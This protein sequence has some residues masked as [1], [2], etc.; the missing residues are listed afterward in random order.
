MRHFTRL[1][2]LKLLAGM[3]AAAP[4]AASSVAITGAAAA[5]PASTSSGTPLSTAKV[6]IVVGPVQSETAKYIADGESAYATAI[7]YSSNVV[8]IYSPNATWANVKAALTGASVVLY[9]GH[10]NGWPSPYPADPTYSKMDG[11]GLN[12]TANNGDSKTQYYGEPSLA[13]VSMAPNA[14]V[15]LNHLCYASGNSEPQNAAPTLSVAKQRADNFGQGFI[16]AGARAVIAEGH[17]SIDGMIRDLFTTHQSVVDLWRTQYDYHHNEFSFQSMRN[18]AY[19]VFMDPDQPTGGY[20]RSFVGN[21]SVR[22][23]NVTGVPFVPTDTAPAT[24]QSPGA[25]TVPAGGANLYNDSSLTS[26][27]SSLA[28]GTN[29]RVE[30]LSNGGSALIVGATPPPTAYVRAMDGSAEGWTAAPALTPQDSTGPQ[31]WGLDGSLAIS[32][33]GDGV[34]DTMN[35]AVRFSESVTW[36]A[37]IL[38]S[39]GHQAWAATGSGA[40]TA[41]T[42][43]A[44]VSGALV[45]NGTYALT[46]RAQDAWGN[47]PL[48]DSLTLTIDASVLPTRLSGADRY[49]TAAAISKA[50]YA[51]GV[52]VAYVASGLGFADALAGAAAAGKTGG[53]LLT[54]PGTTIPAATAAE[55][56]RLKP[57]RIIV[58]GGTSVVSD[59]VLV[60]MKGSIAS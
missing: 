24:L 44:K 11:L 3:L 41:L 1:L 37:S 26:A 38:N 19:S 57:A 48:L 46:I 30:G 22:T 52:P 31:L 12:A 21:P 50:T 56:T 36:S 13:T 33:N 10:G 43:D 14:V 45:P 23:E 55:L 58:L 39:G 49:A 9:I 7:Q 25:A 28:A 54:V 6:V 27:H 16:K 35:L 40:T 8:K 59:G 53:P 47:T 34:A 18:G 29:V 60:T 17:G 51:P 4:V 2:L 42:W 32:P 20:Y 5:A 15:L